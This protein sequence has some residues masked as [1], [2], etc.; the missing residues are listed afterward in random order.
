M[1]FSFSVICFLHFN[2]RFPV[3]VT[4][5]CFSWCEWPYFKYSCLKGWLL[6]QHNNLLFQSNFMK[7]NVS[8]NRISMYMSVRG[9]FVT[10]SK[11]ALSDREGKCLVQEWKT[12]SHYNP[13]LFASIKNIFGERKCGIIFSLSCCIDW[14][15]Q[16]YYKESG[17]KTGYKYAIYHNWINLL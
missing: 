4:S 3:S 17:C 2:S 5:L 7:R 1:F 16:W 6:K 9:L 11:S 10:A 12:K 14:R 13:A 8:K 15:P